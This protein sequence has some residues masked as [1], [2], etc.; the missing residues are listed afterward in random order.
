MTTQRPPL[1]PETNNTTGDT[2]L[3]WYRSSIVWLGIAITLIVLAGCIH[4]VIITRSLV[5][6]TP[7]EAA[8]QKELS[9]ILGVPLSSQPQSTPAGPQQEASV[10]E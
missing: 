2:K 1:Q 5:A 9:R 4:F 10:K 7:T 3:P 6:A 8:P